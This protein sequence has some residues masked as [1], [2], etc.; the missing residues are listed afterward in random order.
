[1]TLL[2]GSPGSGK[3]TLLKALSGRLKSKQLKVCT[4]VFAAAPFWAKAMPAASVFY[5][6]TAAEWIASAAVAQCLKVLCASQLANAVVR[7][8][9]QQQH[10]L[11]GR[12]VQLG[13]H[14]HYRA[15]Q[16]KRCMS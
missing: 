5:L 4:L 7:Q 14:Q 15:G 16:D 8:F 11:F 1:M 6:A 3:S 13:K 2:L 9:C 12:L 10:S